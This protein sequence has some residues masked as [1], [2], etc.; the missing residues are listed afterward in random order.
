MVFLK[1]LCWFTLL[2]VTFPLMGGER[3]NLTNTRISTPFGAN[4][5]TS[6]LDGRV[7]IGNVYEN[8]D[9]MTTRWLF[10]TFRPEALQ[11]DGEG[12]VN[13][14]GT[15]S[16]GYTAEVHNGENALALCFANPT[17]PY[18]M[19]GGQ[20]VYRGWIFDSQMFGTGPT[21]YHFRRRSVEIR[22]SS[23][24][25]TTAEVTGV[26]MGNLE[27][28]STSGGSPLKGIEP[29]LT[30][31][32]H[33]FMFQGGPNNDGT[34]DHLMYTY[35]PTPCGVTGWSTPKT[36][37][38]MY[39]DPE[40]GLD[41]YP[42]SWQPLTA[43]T[44][45][46]FSSTSPVRAAYPWVDHEGRNVLYM[47]VNFPAPVG[48]RREA[49]S[50]IGAD[51]GWSAWHIDGGINARR[52][53]DA[54]LFYS[55]P[56]W[57]LEQERP[58]LLTYPSGADQS[59]HYL[60]VSKNHDILPLFGSNTADYNEVDL[61]DRND[62]FQLLYL[63][64]NELVTLQGDY[65]LTRTP[66]LSGNFFTTTLVGTGAISSTND[67]TSTSSLWSPHGRGKALVISGAGGARAR[68]KGLSQAPLPGFTIQLAIK[69]TPGQN[70]GCGGDPWRYLLKLKGVMEVV[71]ESDGSVQPSLY[72]GGKWV[73]LGH[74][75]VLP[76]GQ[77]SHL[78]W[79]YDGQEV[80]EYLNGLPTG[81]QIAV[82][83]D[84]AVRAGLLTIGSGEIPKAGSCP[85][86]GASFQGVIDE[87]R[88]FNHAR[89]NRSICLST[90]GADCIEDAVQEVPTGPQ[91]DL[92]AQHPGCNQ[93]SALGSSSCATAFHRVCAQRGT[94]DAL[95]NTT[96]VWNT[97]S[98][99]ISDRPPIS[100]AGVAAAA[101]GNLVDVACAPIENESYAVEF[102]ALA[103]WHEG[104]LH[105]QVAMDTTCSAASHR[106]CNSLGWS[107]GTIFELTTRPWVS[108][109]ES[110]LVQMVDRTSLGCPGSDWTSSTC[111]LGISAWCQGRGYDAGL[112]QEAQPNQAE[113]HCFDGAL[114]Q[115][116]EF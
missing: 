11:Y 112:I 83:G 51:T 73:R 55:G 34:I 40:G 82:S 62:P 108:C 75:P 87:V 7:F 115:T 111:R 37:H 2:F 76:Q 28:L 13:F 77:W 110:G 68:L 85:E 102:S 64:M 38:Q 90:P 21:F 103:R 113:V 65:D 32:G 16:A 100:L 86:G 61:G 8:A 59:A 63:P 43:A 5:S 96:N 39:S 24:F 20:A 29:T 74:G 67:D 17:Q 71:Y 105:E 104:C 88:M 31:D 99:L 93:T 94:L 114:V 57:M 4:G 14:S 72:I 12:K 27:F 107:T 97:V 56:M 19:E 46:K 81:R 98:Q 44:G 9:T 48:G 42:L 47:S 80:R 30:A 109:F 84:F 6:S 50:L 3:P 66:D 78:A 95:A 58:G 35:N 101:S 33:L 92:T 69:P 53:T 54:K 1:R 22:V 52:S 36:L 91:F 106:F 60:S 49:V 89:S 26:S 116:W 18:V 15:F 45:E 70:S 25:T 41:R 79:S 23:P 10:R